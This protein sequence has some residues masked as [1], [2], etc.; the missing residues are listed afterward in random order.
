MIKKSRGND[1]IYEMLSDPL[2]FRI[3]NS[4]I[5]YHIEDNVV[6]YLRSMLFIR[7][8]NLLCTF[9]IQQIKQSDK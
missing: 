5:P 4:I 8:I 2:I 3:K 9:S 1:L 6:I 7:N